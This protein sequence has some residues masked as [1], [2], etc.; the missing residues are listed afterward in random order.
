MWCAALYGCAWCAADAF[1]S[2]AGQS[3]FAKL[4]LGFIFKAGI[5]RWLAWLLAT[6]AGGYGY[7][8]RR[9]RRKY[10]VMLGNRN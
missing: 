7:Y 2:L 9:L 10:E 5:D 4:N 3:T 1:K 8:E 6:L